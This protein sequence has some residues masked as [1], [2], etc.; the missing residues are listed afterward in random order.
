M[1]KLTPATTITITTDRAS[2]T[3]LTEMSMPPTAIQ[4]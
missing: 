2:R 3:K 4:E 1:M